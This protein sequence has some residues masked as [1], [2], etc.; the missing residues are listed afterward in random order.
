MAA[1]CLGQCGHFSS[2]ANGSLAS[3][4][5][6]HQLRDGRL[7]LSQGAHVR[8]LLEGGHVVV[9]VQHIDPDAARGLL[10]A[11]VPGDD[12]QGKALD[13]L[14]VQSG[15][16]QDKPGVLIQREPVPGRRGKTRRALGLSGQWTGAV[17][18]SLAL[19]TGTEGHK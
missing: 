7:I 9:D 12:C 11:P 19:P 8:I 6:P 5:E 18:T 15:D 3:Y 1:G 10:A 2:K 13:E 17:F 4:P 16:Q 14:V